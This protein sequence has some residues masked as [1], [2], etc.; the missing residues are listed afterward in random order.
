M[1]IKAILS[2]WGSCRQPHICRA[3]PGPAARS[4]LPPRGGSV[5]PAPSLSW[6]RGGACPHTPQKHNRASALQ[7]PDAAEHLKY[8]PPLARL[9]PTHRASAPCMRGLPASAPGLGSRSVGRLEC[10]RSPTHPPS[11]PWGHG[12]SAVADGGAAK[13]RP[14]PQQ[15][16]LHRHPSHSSLEL[17]RPYGDPHHVT[18]TVPRGL[19]HSVPT[20]RAQSSRPSHEGCPTDGTGP[21]R[22]RLMEGWAHSHIPRAAPVPRSHTHAG[23]APH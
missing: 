7:K 19:R 10:D 15:D 22:A 20:L 6:D 16:L 8:P 17:A 11:P 13:A 2:C 5:A 18:H 14:A 4:P 21:A 9:P 12:R 1:Q 3:Q 23:A